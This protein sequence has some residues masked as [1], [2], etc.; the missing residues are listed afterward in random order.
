MC[1]GYTYKR[2]QYILP[3]EPLNEVK[4]LLGVKTETEAVILSLQEVLKRR[5]MKEIIH[6]ARKFHFD[7]TQ[8]GLKKQRARV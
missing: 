8:T 1:M 4:K 7:L 3:Q 5:N 6:L 2:K